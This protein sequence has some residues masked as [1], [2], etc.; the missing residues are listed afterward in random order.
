MAK[1]LDK[2]LVS[3]LSKKKWP[4]FWQ[5]KYLPSLLSPSEKRLIKIFAL[6]AVG[7]LL[8]LI[9]VPSNSKI[10]SFGGEYREGINGF[11][12]LIN[13][14]LA[15]TNIDLDLSSLIFSGLLKF[16]QNL[17]LVPDLALNYEIK[18]NKAK[19]SIKKNIFWHDGQILKSDD[20]IFTFEAVKN[21]KF[22]SP[23]SARYKNIK[24]K[25]I[26]DWNL[27]FFVSSG[28]LEPSLFT[29]GII[30][31]QTISLTELNLR[32]VGSGPFQFKNLVRD[33]N[34][35]LIKSITLIRNEKY[36]QPVFLD[37]IT[38]KF[39][40]DSKAI[41]EAAIKKEI[42]GISNLNQENKEKL[43]KLG[44]FRNYLLSL[45]RYNAIFLLS[46]NNKLLE[47][48]IF[49]K[50]LAYAA[51]KNL[52]MEEVLKNE[53]EVSQGPILPS[54]FFY[55]PE[56]K[57]YPFDL[58]KAK[59]ILENAGFEK[60]LNLTLTTIDQEELKKTAEI[61]ANKW[62]NLGIKIKLE[63]IPQESFPEIVKSKS[64]QAL[65]FGVIESQ[66][67]PNL[68]GL[69]HSSQIKDG[70]NLSGFSIRKADEL[71]EKIKLTTDKEE[72]K[73]Y[74]FEVQKII[75]EEVPAIFLYHS[76][77]GWLVDKKIKGIEIKKIIL[78]RDRF[79]GIENWYIKTK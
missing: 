44:N 77:Y 17:D 9:F 1:D 39:Y 60:D 78:P 31:K 26:D 32:P 72:E 61:V 29:L 63:I 46:K 3:Q 79:I 64:Y 62:Q 52:I 68:Y 51:P 48:K 47:N 18:E 42:D 21:P 66:I 74:Y 57:N 54:S 70:L 5:L 73:N 76:F 34:S 25:K 27:E 22:D 23:Y 38:F 28:I 53:G 6:I 15:T 33:K 58:E 35:K 69:W 59:K 2:I 24:I 8:L 30:P 56:I 7:G 19:F 65:L 36:H 10:P 13:P 16:N 50:V 41:I 14:I 55:N 37:K 11:P 67:E 45:P 4:H 75:S 71:M 12:S 20:I 43:L 49:R 40:S